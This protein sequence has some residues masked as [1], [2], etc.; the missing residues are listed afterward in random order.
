MTDAVCNGVSMKKLKVV[1]V[2]G[3]SHRMNDQRLTVRG[4]GLRGIN[5]SVIVADT[6]SFR[7]M[8]KKVIH[9]VRVE[10]LPVEDGNG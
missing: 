2:R 10:A 5:S 6:P 1:Q 3:L 7:G 4:L 9:L 8:I